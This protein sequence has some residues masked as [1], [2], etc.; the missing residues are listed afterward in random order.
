MDTEQPAAAAAAAAAVT[1]QGA[2]PGPTLG[3]NPQDV[4]T[5]ASAAD[6]K[7]DDC[8][9]PEEGDDS[10]DEDYELDKDPEVQRKRCKLLRSTGSQP[11]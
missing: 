9:S 1:Q 8:E 4:V 6:A 10:A 11:H 2:G 3:G 5:A 7:T